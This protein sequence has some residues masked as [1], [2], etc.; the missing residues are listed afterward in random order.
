MTSA[1]LAWTGHALVDV[2]IAGLV[3]FAEKNAPG[4]LT[5]EDLDRASEWMVDHYYSGLLG[6]Y[7]SC[8]FMNAFVRTERRRVLR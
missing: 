4:E 1:R 7:L 5:L 2:G 6:T 8:V 3:V